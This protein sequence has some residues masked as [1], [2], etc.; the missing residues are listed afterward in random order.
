MATITV[1]KISETQFD[2]IIDEK[3]VDMCK[4]N[5]EALSKII[6]SLTANDTKFKQEELKVKREE[7]KQ[8]IERTKQIPEETKQM[9][10]RTKQIPEETK[11]MIERTKQIPEETKQKQTEVIA[12]S[13]NYVCKIATDM[14]KLVTKLKESDEFGATLSHIED[15][16][17]D[18]E[19]EKDIKENYT[20]SN[21]NEIVC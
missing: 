6:N 8:M 3:I 21:E 14:M 10:E 15:T 9:I 13:L 18:E 12:S 20:F 2:Y 11:Q 19:V 1:K 17:T 5:P 7:T 4:D 16:R